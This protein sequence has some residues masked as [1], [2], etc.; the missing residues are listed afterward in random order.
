M[1][2]VCVVVGYLHQ[3]RSYGRSISS[4]NHFS[5]SP[6]ITFEDCE[7]AKLD[8]PLPLNEAGFL[9]TYKDGKLVRLF[10]TVQ[11]N[12]TLLLGAVNFYGAGGV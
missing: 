6:E 10:N 11:N 9:W 3:V 1:T 2:F 12:R 8:D 5:P 4:T 7:K